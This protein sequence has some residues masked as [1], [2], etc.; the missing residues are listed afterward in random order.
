MKERILRRLLGIALD[1]LASSMTIAGPSAGRL[2]HELCVGDAAF[3]TYKESRRETRRLLEESSAL[4]KRGEHT[5]GDVYL[6]RAIMLGQSIVTDF[7][8]HVPY[9]TQSD[10][11]G[12]PS[13]WGLLVEEYGTG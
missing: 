1:S 7:G 4:F 6:T 2:K 10:A 11:H 12:Q 13:F 3:E 9:V 5:A 8:P